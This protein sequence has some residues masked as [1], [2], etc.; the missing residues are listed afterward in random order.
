MTQ[1]AIINPRSAGGRTGRRLD[2][3][4]TGLR[5]AIGPVAHQ[6]TKGPR[7]A[8]RLA[9]EA[10]QRGVTRIIAVGGDGT[11]HE[12]VNGFFKDGA[13]L[14][15][16]AAFSFLMSGSGGDFKRS[17][18]A[19]DGIAEGLAYLRQAAPRRIDLGHVTCIG[20]DG[21]S[22]ERHFLNISSFGLSGDVVERVNRAR[23][24][25]LLGGPFSFKLNSLLALLAM[26]PAR[27]HLTGSF[28]PLTLEVSTLAVC[29]GRFFGGGMMIAPDA[30]LDDGLFDVV[31]I[32]SR[33]KG[34]M[35]GR[36]ND[37]YTGKHL[38]H[39]E[40]RHW[41]ASEL[42]AEP[43]GPAP[44]LLE[45]DGE[46]AARLPARFRILRQALTLW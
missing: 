14:N 28:D 7:D 11:L 45:S 8:T 36:M 3:I 33:R 35:A 9:R 23:L 25:K 27:V 34:E 18:G 21:Q 41:R 22:Q 20:P 19:G 1:L 10:L 38:Q 13:P 4:L 30:V 31:A 39:P 44:V 42:N 15:P 26:R 29:N 24:S 16:E 46:G 37:I 12:T 5:A 6:L 32:T 17:A 43:A 40:V 2:E